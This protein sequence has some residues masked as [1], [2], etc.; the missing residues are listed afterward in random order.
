[1]LADITHLCS[2][3]KQYAAG[4][5]GLLQMTYQDLVQSFDLVGMGVQALAIFVEYAVRPGNHDMLN[6][7]T[8]IQ[9]RAET[10]AVRPTMTPSPN[11]GKLYDML[12]SYIASFHNLK[13]LATETQL[14]DTI[15]FIATVK[16]ASGDWERIRAFVLILESTCELFN[17]GRQSIVPSN[18]KEPVRLR[19]E[20]MTSA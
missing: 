16:A 12:G 10:K 1:M 11:V 17:R 20:F 8:Q 4:T 5:N 18:M 15:N 3:F 6:A 7:L 13:A 14:V 19:K 9:P 2:S